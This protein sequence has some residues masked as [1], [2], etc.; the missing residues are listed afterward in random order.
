MLHLVAY[1]ITNPKRL[2][3]VAKTC[4]D[5]GMRVEYSLFECDLDEERLENMRSAIKDIMDPDEDSLLIYRLCASCV[6]RIE[7]IGSVTRP[8]KVLLYFP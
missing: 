8:E 4:E 7:A 3:R 6:Q 1:D 5:Y 2:R